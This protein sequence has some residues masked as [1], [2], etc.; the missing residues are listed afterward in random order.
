L[1][2]KGCRLGWLIRFISHSVISGFTSASAIIIAFSQAKSFLGYSV[3]RS[4]KIIPLVESIYAGRSQFK[5]Q[6]FVMGSVVLA[7]L[8]IMKHVGKTYKHLKFFRAAGPITAV[9]FST[10]FVKLVRPSSISVVGNIPQGLPGLSL[11]YRFEAASR[12]LPTAA[13]ITGVAIL[14]QFLMCKYVI[15]VLCNVTFIKNV[16][17]S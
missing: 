4:S 10:I 3:T 16:Q 6:P 7:V 2:L 15:E 8:L 14:V 11:D 9:F 1:G 5:W 17:C 12:L 13:L